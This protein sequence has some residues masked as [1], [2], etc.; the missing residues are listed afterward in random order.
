MSE[1]TAPP[2][3]PTPGDSTHPWRVTLDRLLAPVRHAPFTLGFLAVLWIVGAVTGSLGGGPSRHRM[4]HVGIGVPALA[5]GRWWT[6]V[7][8]L[9]W[10][11]GLG[12]YLGATA[13]VLLLVTPSERRLGVARTAAVLI[14]G[15]ILGTLLGT[16]IVQLGNAAGEWWLEELAGYLAVSPTVGALAVGGVLSYRLTALWRRRTRLGIVAFALVMTLYVGHLQGVLRLGGAAVGLLLGAVLYRRAGP[17]RLRHSSHTEAR[18]LVALVVA[19]AAIGPM[20]AILYR[21][22][23]GPLN[24]F[25]LYV[26]VQPTGQEVADACAASAE[27][28][29]FVHALRNF[30]DSPAAVMAV[31]VPALMLVLAEGLRRG[32]RLAWTLAVLVHLAWIALFSWWLHDF[33]SHP[34]GWA[35]PAERSTYAQAFAEQML[36][37]VLIVALLIVTRARFGLRLPRS[38]TRGLAAVV[39][40]SLVLACAAYVG[41]GYAVRDQYDPA[42]TPSV[43]FS[44]LASEFLPPTL[45]ATFTDWPVP[46]GGT[47]QALFH[48][49]GL[50][51]WLVTLVALLVTFR[52]PRLHTDADAAVR[53]RELLTGHGGSTLSFL[54]TWDGNYYWFDAAGRSAVAYRVIA[55]VAL[56]TGEPFGAPDA[57]AAAVGG[58]ARHCDERGWTPCFYS[59]GEEA[60][61]AAEALGW[62]SVQVAEDTVVPLP[63]LAFTGKKWQDVRTALNKAKKEGITAEWWS[64]PEAPVALTDQIRSISEE[65]VADKGLPEMGFTL[66]GLEELDDPAVRCL[67]A[68][69]GDRTVHGITSWMPVYEAGRPAGWTLDFMRRRAAGFRGSMEFLIASA[70]LGFQEEGA[71]FLSLSG[72]PLARKATEEP[73]AAL[74]RILDYGGKVLEPVYGF[75]SLLNFKSKFQPQYHPMYMAYPDPAALPAITRAIGKAYLPH[76]TAAQGVRLMRQFSA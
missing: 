51:F 64:Y 25:Q 12:G 63:G 14:G 68:V 32:L 30:Y 69:D 38:A 50:V 74:Q 34:A 26:S 13:I 15:Q 20:V 71:R 35:E 31:L 72:A 43:L 24:S 6:P 11:P 47:A 55:T 40:G 65:W 10:C 58:F 56:T 7:S 33:L 16:G 42:A 53:A 46:V 17:L 48:Y 57:R 36:L 45:L 59:V 3:A 44:G 75:R 39:G 2:P 52:R 67:I 8:S 21:D 29:H 27:D 73:P 1:T 4:E 28:C 49:C 54:T 22:A 37:P 61:A 19:A 60:R 76:M 62:R 23:Y 18:V 41:I 9:L 5:E 70:A 66:G